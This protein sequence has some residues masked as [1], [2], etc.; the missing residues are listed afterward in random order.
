M[1]RLILTLDN[2]QHA[3]V[4]AYSAALGLDIQRVGIKA[5]NEHFEKNNI[6]IK[7]PDR[8]KKD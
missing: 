7:L 8:P 1:K 3:K 5:L 4:K 6:D 2:D